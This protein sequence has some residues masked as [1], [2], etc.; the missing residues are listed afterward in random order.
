M[1]IWE[2]IYLQ[3]EKEPITI[4]GVFYLPLP[5]DLVRYLGIT[6]KTTFVIQDDEGK[7]GKYVSFWIKDK[8]REK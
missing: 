5:I 4:S 6:E 3:F 8:M 1:I 7:H 2:V